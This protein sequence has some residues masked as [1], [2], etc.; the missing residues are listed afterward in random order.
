MAFDPADTS[1]VK[2]GLVEET[3][4]GEFP[5]GSLEEVRFA[6]E[7]FGQSQD[8]TQSNEIRADQQVPDIIRTAVSGSGGYSGELS[9][10]VLS[11]EK[12]LK[13]LVGA[14][15]D[16]T[17]P[18]AAIT[19]TFNAT[20]SSNEFDDNSD[21]LD[22]STISVGDWIRTSGFSN[23]ANNGFFQVTAVDTGSVPQTITV[24]GADLV[25]ETGDADESVQGSSVLRN[26]T[27]EVSFAFEKQFDDLSLAVR[28]LGYKPGGLQ[29]TLNPGEIVTYQ[30]SGQGAQASD[31]AGSDLTDASATL[32]FT[33]LA[34]INSA[35]ANSI[36]STSTGVADIVLNRDS[37]FSDV[38]LQSLTL[39][40]QR[41]L[42]QQNA[43]TAG[44]APAGVAAGQ[45]SV[46]G[47]ITAYF[48]DKKLLQE[49]LRFS[50]TDVAVAVKDGANNAYLVDVPAVKL[51]GDAPPK[52]GGNNQDALVETDMSGFRS[53]RNGLDYS[54]AVHKFSA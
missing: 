31:T 4:F 22:L 20:A 39:N 3:N 12:L 11:W 27:N 24:V 14:G 2:L 42:R 9:Y 48:E 6:S 26:D 54:F 23:A 52:A 50:T 13:A 5:G 45:F 40:P 10:D 25:D 28:L 53:T 38:T 16:F 18:P 35:A 34:T 47:N 19:G 32:D 37:P 33:T 44:I 21:G 30:W 49:Y 51:G 29:L 15:S 1:R 7:S 41:N 17:S 46:G 43:L 8:T 36:M